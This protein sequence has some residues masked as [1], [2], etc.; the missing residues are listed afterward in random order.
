M[1]A[2]IRKTIVTDIAPGPQS[3]APSPVWR[4]PARQPLRA[5]MPA[6]IRKTTVT[7]TVPGPQSL[8]PNPGW[9]VPARQTLRAEIARRI[10]KTTVTDIVPGPQ[11]L[12]PNPVW[13]VPARQTLRGRNS[14]ADSQDNCNGCCA[15]SPIP[16]PQSRLARGRTPNSQSLAPNPVWR[17]AARQTLPNPKAFPLVADSQSR[18]RS[19]KYRRNWLTQ[20]M[21][22]VISSA[23]TCTAWRYFYCL[24][25]RRLTGASKPG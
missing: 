15:R 1:P 12:A 25:P 19:R 18:C 11:S 20:P 7:D 17:V 10:R 6:Q 5:E 13:R 8:A 4:V 22:S 14:P 16:S 24:T 3:L 9:R 23:S 21:F 2:Q